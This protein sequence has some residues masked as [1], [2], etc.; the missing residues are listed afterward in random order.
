MAVRANRKSKART[1]VLP[2]SV[3][4]VYRR[5]LRTIVANQGLRLVEVA[6]DPSSGRM[7]DLGDDDAEDITAVVIPQPNFFGL[8][9]EVD[10]WTN[11][12]HA[13]NALV[14]ALVNHAKMLRDLG[15]YDTV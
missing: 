7:A 3:H 5:V 2:T 6:F 11:W 14:I 4:P 12:A 13:R 15:K 10:Q 9:E 1:V 8:L